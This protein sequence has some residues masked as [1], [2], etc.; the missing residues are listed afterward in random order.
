M[1][2][3]LSNPLLTEADIHVAV[4]SRQFLG[5]GIACNIARLRI[6]RALGD[7][8]DNIAGIQDASVQ[9][10]AQAGV[11]QANEGISQIAQA[12]FAGEAPPA[13]GRDITEAGLTAASSALDSGDAYVFPYQA[14][15]NVC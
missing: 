10:T 14:L 7:T 6:V 12:I 8:S 9:Q 13:E 1:N 5:G 15:Y 11:D 2:T 4:V 3:P